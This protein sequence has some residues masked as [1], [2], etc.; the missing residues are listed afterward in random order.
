MEMISTPIRSPAAWRGGEQ[1]KSRSWIHVL[2]APEIDELLRAARELKA[3]GKALASIT[4]RDR[5]LP[6]LGPVIDGWMRELDDGRGFVLV[7]GF[8][9]EAVPEDEAALAYWII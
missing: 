3:G 8:P 5:P 1:A 9:V 7:K 2:S 6:R 4:A